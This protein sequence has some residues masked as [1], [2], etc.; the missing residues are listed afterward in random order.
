MVCALLI[1][2][3]LCIVIEQKGKA[4]RV[5]NFSDP[6]YALEDAWLL[7]VDG[8][9]E[10][11][12]TLPM[13][14]YDA[15]AEYSI[16]HV[17][18]GQEGPKSAPGIK[19][20]SYYMAFDIYLND[21]LLYSYPEFELMFSKTMGSS[22][23]FIRLPEDYAGKELRIDFSFMLKDSVGYLLE[24]PLFGSKASMLN[25]MLMRDLPILLIDIFTLVIGIAMLGIYCFFRL[26]KRYERNMTA[27]F[28]A[29]FAIIFGIYS[30][31]EA[32]FMHYTVQNSYLLYQ[33]TFSLLSLIAVPLLVIFKENVSNRF[34]RLIICNI[35]LVFINFFVQTALNYLGILDYREML[36]V[37]HVI[38]LVSVMVGLYCLV[39]TGPEES[40]GRKRMLY[41]TV[42]LFVGA[43]IDLTGQYVEINKYNSLFFQI[44]VIIFILVQMVYFARSYAILYRNL[45]QNELYRRMAFIDLLTGLGNR[46]AYERHLAELKEDL[47][48]GEQALWCFVADI[49]NLKVTNDT[50]GHT[51]GDQLIVDTSN[52]IVSA[53]PKEKSMAFRIGGDEF[54]IF[55]RDAE[56]NSIDRIVENIQAN[57]SEY[58]K[59][60]KIV[61]DVAFGYA[62]Y[63]KEESL[64]GFV[65]RADEL[66]YQ[67][68]MLCHARMEV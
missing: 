44:G 5:L 30:L 7:R 51:V 17:L 34:N 55:I 38:Q 29:V 47:D 35:Y 21:E 65:A 16:R 53:F 18:R 19:I 6:V 40:Q 67:H 63:D 61:I 22:Y 54:V 62:E 39:R 36:P 27:F 56:K 26:R 37:T 20:F 24:A 59:H 58:N 50:Y 45:V 31:A 60:H 15:Q 8:G 13:K 49:N 57:I 14:F 11:Q 1:I 46:N 64:T 25:E 4:Y 23:H 66:M 32:D 52:I 3:V 48:D 12:I 9:K 42:P 68:K 28:T 43:L 10:E 2:L 33:L 41:S